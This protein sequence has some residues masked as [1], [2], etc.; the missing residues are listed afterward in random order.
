MSDLQIQSENHSSG[1]PPTPSTPEFSAATQPSYTRT[2]FLGPDGLRPGWGF[3]FYV[4]M[5]YT[6]QKIAV[7]LAWARDFGFSGLWS[8]LLEEFGNFLAAVIP[9]LVLCRIGRRPWRTYGLPGSEAFRKSF[10]QGISWGIGA[11]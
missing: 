3:A 9:S 2:L 5:F 1:V 8:S 7:D 10:W 11:I 6:L 4:V